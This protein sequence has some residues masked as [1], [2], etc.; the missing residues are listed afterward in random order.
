MNKNLIIIVTLFLLPLM[1]SCQKEQQIQI[2]LSLPTQREERWVR[3][4][5]TMINE[6]QN[7]GLDLKVLV[8]DN[9]SALQIA[10]CEELLNAG[11]KVLILAPH[12]ALTASTIV[13]LAKTH[14][15]PVISYDRL[16]LNADVDY[17]ISFNNW[18]VGRIQARY[19]LSKVPEGNFVVMSG[20][21]S[22]NNAKMFND[23][24]MEILTTAVESGS[25]K[26]LMNKP[27]M[28]WQ[29]SE[30]YKLMEAALK[31]YD[32]ID[33]V[34]A[35]NDGTA[36][37]IIKALE[38][39]GKIGEIPVTGQDGEIEAARLIVKGH[40]SMTVFKDTRLLGKTA[41]ELT[42]KLLNNDPVEYDTIGVD[43]G[44]SE[45]PSILL[46]PVLV[47]KENLDEILIESG[48]I[49]RDDIY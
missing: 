22:D 10:Q 4:K 43:N 16:V 8:S 9:D 11:I 25:I 19:L 39:A 34:L 6:A 30:A 29:P 49:K 24:A 46:N 32:R 42:I 12:D 37:G 15:V 47:T 18:E 7:H 35:P 45:I 3:D 21:P 44:Y 36:R 2:G 5:E 20:S 23:G 31:E 27:I 41:I 40:Q 28:D 17:Y 48:Y 38:Q 26:I 33:A 14:N 1:L 13:E